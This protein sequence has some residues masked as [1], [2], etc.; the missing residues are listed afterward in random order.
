[1]YGRG[2]FSVEDVGRTSLVL[3]L[4]SLGL[5][6]LSLQKVSASAFFSKGDTWTPLKASFIS[7]LSE[8]LTA[9]SFLFLLDLGL[10]GLPL[11]TALSSVVGFGYLFGRLDVKPYPKPILSTLLRVLPSLTLMVLFLEGLKGRAGGSVLEVLLLVPS[12]ALLYLFSLLLLRE[13]L[14]L[15][16]LKGLVQKVVKP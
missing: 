11:A 5:L 3:S 12:G 13:P 2:N 1:M 6:F 7:V 15:G 9:S 8:G 16:L 4:Y 10:F 14:I